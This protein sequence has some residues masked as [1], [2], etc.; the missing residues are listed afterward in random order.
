MMMMIE[1]C[2]VTL[3]CWSQRYAWEAL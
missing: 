1:T 2:P 3:C